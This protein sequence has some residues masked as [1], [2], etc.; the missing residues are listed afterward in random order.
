VDAGVTHLASTPQGA[1][2]VSGEP[3][4][5]DVLRGLRE[6]AGVS[7]AQVAAAL[8]IPPTSYKHYEARFNKPHLPIEITRQLA[9]YFNG[10][11]RPPIRA[12]DV[13]R[14]AGPVELFTSSSYAPQQ[15]PNARLHD[16]APAP[17]PGTRD[18]PVVHSRA[19][20]WG[21]LI[22]SLAAA[23]LDYVARPPAL[24]S[25][26]SIWALTIADASLS[27]RY[28]PGE[29]VYCDPSRPPAVGGY[30]V[31]ILRSEADHET[32]AHVGRI[33]AITGSEVRVATLN[34]PAERVIDASE[35]Q[36]IARILTMGE[37]LTH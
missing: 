30:G 36:T 13:M 25:N 35:I 33:T 22:M 29:R 26:R 17:A 21:T 18:V 1:S 34:P 6:R 9:S 12:T 24:A 10:R 3:L 14:L 20:G 32:V 28:D 15:A 19:A 7:A 27:P 8:G 2:R 23:P 16:Y 11:G 31:V 37:M 5:R 4:V